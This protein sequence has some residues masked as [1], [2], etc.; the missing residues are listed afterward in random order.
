M[1]RAEP[2]LGRTIQ[3]SMGMYG[4]NMVIATVTT[5]LMYYY[6]PPL[7]R[8]ALGYPVLLHIGVFILIR[9][10]GR[11]VDVIA[12]PVVTYLS[13]KCRHPMGRRKPFIIYGTLPLTFFCI[14]I[15][16]P[17]TPGHS[18]LNA[19]WFSLGVVGVWIFYT[20]VVAPYLALHPQLF[21]TESS[22]MRSSVYMSYFEV[23]ALLVSTITAGMIIEAFDK[24]GLSLGGLSLNGFQVAAIIYAVTGA[25]S[26]YIATWG[27]KEELQDEAEVVPFKFSEAMLL[28]FKNRAFIP[29]LF[30]MASVRITFSCIMLGI[31]YMGRSFFEVGETESSIMF[32][33][34]ILTAAAFFPIT[35]KVLRRFGLKRT[36]QMALA[37]AL[38]VMPLMFFTKSLP[39]FP[40]QSNISKFEDKIADYRLI[41]QLN[42]SG[43]LLAF[44]G[45]K[46]QL[47]DICWWLRFRHA[48]LDE[49]KEA[50][51]RSGGTGMADFSSFRLSDSQIVQLELFS[52]S[53]WTTMAVSQPERFSQ[54]SGLLPLLEQHTKYELRRDLEILQQY[55]KLT[56]EEQGLLA[57]IATPDWFNELSDEKLMLLQEQIAPLMI[58][59]PTPVIWAFILY[60]LM[61]IPAAFLLTG[62]RPLLGEIIDEDEK[63][64]G[65]RRE[66]IYFG[67]E[68]LGTKSG[69]LVANSIGAYIVFMV[70]TRGLDS[71][72]YLGF[73]A[74][75]FLF[76]LTA[77]ISISF[78]P[79]GRPANE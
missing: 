11:I 20:V 72:F 27:I 15:W 56:P 37:M 47:C 70:I 74:A 19:A 13:D 38:I 44:S 33:L 59:F 54:F 39:S 79:L 31:P 75:A 62:Y 48:P 58:N 9:N 3:Y 45:Q 30:L 25:L 66:A 52:S 51:S 4:V 67:M 78:Y 42:S 43:D 46:E 6:Y 57:R 14:M 28:T 68:A 12:D 50:L 73:V 61:G 7:E 16:F 29:Y 35:P 69:E 22:R 1:K 26:F 8:Q 2:S 60:A 40:M 55:A 5:W 65:Y 63:L 17:L 24:Q 32:A 77:L 21:H 49:E 18:L 10:L 71:S 36:Y 41:S 64:Y 34:I 76:F 23:L 53:D